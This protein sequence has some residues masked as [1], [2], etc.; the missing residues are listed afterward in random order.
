MQVTVR[1]VVGRSRV[2][3]ADDVAADPAKTEKVTA[4]FL[5]MKKME[6]AKLMEAANT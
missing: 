5:P 6:I 4:A 3:V 2:I 1:R